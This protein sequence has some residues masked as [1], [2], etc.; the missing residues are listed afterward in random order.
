MTNRLLLAAF[1]ALL[2][3]S[4]P[5]PFFA[6]T[7]VQSQK[8]DDPIVGFSTIWS[9]QGE[10]RKRPQRFRIDAIIHYYDPVWHQLWAQDGDKTFFM[11]PPETRLQIRSGQLVRLTGTTVPEHFNTPMS[12]SAEILDEAPTVIPIPASGRLDAPQT[13]NEKWLELEGVVGAQTLNDPDHL[14]FDIEADG[15]PLS[16]ILLLTGNSPVPQLSG[17]R[18]RIRGVF[19]HQID[20]ANGHPLSYL[21]CPSREH[22]VFLPSP[23][24][25][26]APAATVQSPGV[27]SGPPIVGYTKL[28]ELSSADRLRPQRFQIDAIINYYDPVWHMLW[29]Q[30]GDATLFL[31]PPGN[32]LPIRAG[33][34]VRLTGITT[35]ANFAHVASLSARVLND[36][37]ALNPIPIAGQIEESLRLDEHLIE[38]HG[39][40]ES[41]RLDDRN[42]LRCSLV[43]E[44]IRIEAIVYLE[45][46]SPVPALA[47]TLVTARGVYRGQLAPDGR[48]QSVSLFVPGTES[49]A[50]TGLLSNDPR[51]DA[52]VV[53]IELLPE[54]APGSSIHVAGKTVSI[55][56]GHSIVIRDRTGQLELHTPQATSIQAG[57]DVEAIGYPSIDKGTWQLRN[58][59]VRPGLPRHGWDASA[60]DRTIL[61]LASQVLAL[62]REN[63][64][65]QHPVLLQGVVTW[66]WPDSRSIYVQD[67]SGGIRV[68]LTDPAISVPEVGA[69]VTV[70][71][72]SDIGEFAPTV[73]ATRLSSRYGL[74]LPEPLQLSLIEAETGAHEAEWVEMRGLLRDI[75]PNAR[76]TQLLVT[77]PTGD[78]EAQ[79]PS[80]PRFTGLRDAFVR[81]RGVCTALTNEQ[82]QLTAIRLR[83]SHPDMVAVE[84]SPPEDRFAIPESAINSLRQFGPFHTPSHWLRTIGVV[85]YHTPGR[86]LVIQDGA[87]ALTVFLS[88]EAVL[89][90]GDRVEVVGTPG[91]DGVRHGLRNAEVR[92]LGIAPIA[93]PPARISLPTMPGEEFDNRLVQLT[94]QLDEV[95]E[96][97]D[98]R[99]LEIRHSAGALVARWHAAAVPI[100][101][102]WRRGCEIELTGVCRL[103][104]DENRRRTGFE[105]LLRSPADVRILRSTSWWTSARALSA[106]AILTLC[107]ACGVLWVV[108]LRRKV[109]QQTAQLKIQLE[110][111]SHLE[112]EL[113]RAQRLQS[114]GTL[115]GGIAHDFNNLLTVIMGNVTLAMLDETVMARA[116]DCLKEAEAGTQRARELTQQMITFARGGAPIRE[117]IE[118]PALLHEAI[119]LALS[120]S[121]VRAEVHSQPG[122]RPVHADRAQI[123]RA[124]LNLLAHATTSMP[125]GGIVSID[126]ADEF[127]VTGDSAPL[128]RGSYVQVRLSD[129]GT[130]IPAERLPSVFDP[131][132][133]VEEGGDR[134]GLATAYSIARKHGGHLAVRS[135]AAS[136]TTFTLWLP[137]ADNSAELF[138][139]ATIAVPPDGALPAAFPGIRVLFMDDEE[140]I[141]RLVN[142]FL[143][144]LQCHPVMVADGAACL[145]TYGEAQEEGHPFDLVVMDLTVPGGM[146][147]MET[148]A[149]LRK[150]DPAVRAIVSSGY[151][152]DP[153][154]SR[155][156]EHGFVAAVPKPYEVKRLAAAIACAL[157]GR[158]H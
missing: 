134:F 157:A 132:A 19:T 126:L 80:D 78:F 79:V 7:L 32:E 125:Q 135:T 121:K 158:R 112:A 82:R 39:F 64:D 50:I 74:S 146:G 76:A 94:G 149:E 147:G 60:P 56:S 130:P 89:R 16:G 84:E 114:L 63:A 66:S 25:V 45:A 38:I 24:T 120:G 10:A 117:N 106:A 140:G 87:D 142:T 156:R 20:P 86:F 61:R 107:L 68:D 15:M 53:A 144:Q 72:V 23:R 55:V 136:G 154:L 122:L 127:V 6:Q 33:Q 70:E 131:Y 69:G 46:G 150:I 9:I 103:L 71:G 35:P 29:A 62:P 51:F 138:Q 34:R 96:L 3:V 108:L 48:L 97:G 113:E 110:K 153:I 148:L 118:L 104:Y 54:L 102:S 27:P 129:R 49:I 77:T 57:G 99:F 152:A 5:A 91:R 43:A 1:A 141:R 109:S 111:E 36:S 14:R 101:E 21:L 37:P 31:V 116:G 40:V 73:T 26:A 17:A 30:D 12:L 98:E 28:W 2:E 95:T 105:L 123:R 145:A 83:V 139:P 92:S 75:I 13:L 41:Q 67:P 155:Y 88:K 133:A 59:L 52:P 151:A 47:G 81:I 93:V 18:I 90:P 100:P 65:T 8:P 115:A 44:G 42:H 137:A 119:S 4:T 128:T 58:A 22:I 143:R 11:V 124:L 85:T